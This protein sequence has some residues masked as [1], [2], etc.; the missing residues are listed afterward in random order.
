M[1]VRYLVDSG[2]FLADTE[3]DLV[4][5]LEDFGSHQKAKSWH[6]GFF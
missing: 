5:N 4:E 6:Q 2:S 1:L 3:E